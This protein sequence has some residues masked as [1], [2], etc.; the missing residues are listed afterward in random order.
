[1]RLKTWAHILESSGVCGGG[2]ETSLATTDLVISTG[3]CWPK[4]HIKYLK[5]KT[6]GTILLIK[7]DYFRSWA[8]KFIV[9][10]NNYFLLLNYAG[11]YWELLFLSDKIIYHSI[12]TFYLCFIREHSSES[13]KSPMSKVYEITLRGCPKACLILSSLWLR[14]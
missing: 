14:N 10:L 5:K 11:S 3:L 2:P 4:S 12:A 6:V 13:L 1:M 7:I 8:A 9:Y